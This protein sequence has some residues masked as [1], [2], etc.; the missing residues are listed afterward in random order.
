MSLA[1]FFANI[2]AQA[3]AW[4]TNEFNNVIKPLVAKEAAAFK[5]LI[6]ATEQEILQYGI[7]I[8][9]SFFGAAGASLTGS[10][11]MGSAVS[12]LVSQL[13]AAG[14]S[15]AVSDA[16]AALQIA[17]NEIKKGAAAMQAAVATQ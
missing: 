15:I 9:L 7:P 10:Q 17:V 6:Q 1:K 5:P 14:K 13:G 11:K 3:A 12:Q 4:V 2:E 16:Q 8:L